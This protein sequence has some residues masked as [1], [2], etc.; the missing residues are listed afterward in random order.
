MALAAAKN[1]LKHLQ[2]FAKSRDCKPKIIK[3]CTISFFAFIFDDI[4]KPKRLFVCFK[5]SG[6]E[7]RYMQISHGKTGLSDAD[8][9]R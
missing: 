7:I 9:S 6:W 2:C 3:I 4:L 8:A 1:H 5:A